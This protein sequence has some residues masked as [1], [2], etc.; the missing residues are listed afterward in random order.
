MTKMHADELE[1]D[2]EL[3]RRLL[4]D[5]FPEWATIPIVRI[6]PS[7]T[8]NAIFRLGDVMAVRL[9]RRDGPTIEADKEHQ[10]L[11]RLA[12]A[13]PV[14]IPLPVARGRPGAGYPWFWSIVR[15]LEGDTPLGETIDADEL[16]VF[17]A[18]L[19]RVDAAGGPAPG[20]RRGEPLAIR[21]P[22]V[23]RA[24]ENRDVPG[25]AELWDEAM[26]AP[27]WDRERVWLHADIDAR[28]VLVRD[29]RLTGVI[30]WG[31]TGVGD[32]AVDV[33]AAWKLLTLD[34][35]DRFREALEVDD[36][37]WLRARGWALSQAL[38]ALDYY[39][40]ETYPVMVHE[41]ERWLEAVLAG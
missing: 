24:L 31:C 1:L 30:D 19:Q 14:E 40:L 39:T 17:V 16:A 4:I 28:N 27:E 20:V 23:R 15:W 25:A 9:A 33:M 11:P 36:A 12:P 10:W 2:E 32:P 5:Q 7:G 38:I 26:S 13:L 6:E 29:G 22:G 37:T 35:R 8:D 3:V 41:A 21:E 34:G 18:A